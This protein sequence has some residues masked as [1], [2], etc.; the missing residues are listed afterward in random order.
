MDAAKVVDM[1]SDRDI[2]DLLESLDAKPEK[3]GKKYRDTSE[4][5]RN[6]EVTG[7]FFVLLHV[8]IKSGAYEIEIF[9]QLYRD[10]LL[11]NHSDELASLQ[12][13]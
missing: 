3:K 13:I 12:G 9:N 10:N 1:L 5:I 2:W 11:V 8:K 7:F 6:S 4:N